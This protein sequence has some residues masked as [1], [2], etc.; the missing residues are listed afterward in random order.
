MARRAD[1]RY[2]AKKQVVC[3][4]CSVSRYGSESDRHRRRRCRGAAAA[5]RKRLTALPRP[6]ILGA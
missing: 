4:L 2:R 6:A 3:L 1:W 5:T